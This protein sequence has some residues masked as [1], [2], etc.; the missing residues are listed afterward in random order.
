[1][2]SMNALLVTL[3]N[4]DGLSDQQKEWRNKVRKLSCDMED[5]VDRFMHKISEHNGLAGDIDI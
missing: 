5:C 3:T 1:M 2:S 4:M